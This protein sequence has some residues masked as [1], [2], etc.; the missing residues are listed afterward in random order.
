MET[1]WSWSAFH[2]VHT[3]LNLFSRKSLCS[4]VSMATHHN[5]RSVNHQWCI[6][7]PVRER[8]TH[9]KQNKNKVFM[10][11]SPHKHT[12]TRPAHTHGGCG[13]WI[14]DLTDLVTESVGGS[15]F[16]LDSG[17]L[18]FFFPSAQFLRLSSL[19]QNNKKLNRKETGSLW[20]SET[21][22]LYF[23][24]DKNPFLLGQKENLLVSSDLCVCVFC[25][26]HHTPH[27]KITTAFSALRYLWLWELEQLKHINEQILFGGRKIRWLK[28][29]G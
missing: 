1:D 24:V 3:L 20:E 17:T 22:R 2:C 9:I 19:T 14:Q 12:L 4:L 28:I 25:V 29:R 27:T 13:L 23:L 16:Q 6:N 10:A 11:T 26:E 8:K 7:N 18:C 15:R 21:K 5:K